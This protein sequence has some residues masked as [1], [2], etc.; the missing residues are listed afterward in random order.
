VSCATGICAAVDKT[1]HAIVYSGTSWGTL[2][3]IDP[4]QSL[5]SVS[6]T[7]SSFC[8]AV[9]NDGNALTYGG[10]SWTSA[11]IDGTKPLTG[12]SC[13]SSSFCAAVDDAGNAVV[14]GGTSWTVTS[15]DGTTALTAVSC[16]SSSFCAAADGGGAAMTYDGKNWSSPIQADS[17]EANITGLSCASS[18]LCVAVDA[19]N[20]SFLYAPTVTSINTSGLQS[21]VGLP[22]DITAQV[23]SNLASRTPSG[24]VKVSDGIQSCTATLAGSAGIATGTCSLTEQT[25]GT[26]DFV[27]TYGPNS[28]FG[29]SN[30]ASASLTVGN[31]N[32]TTVLASSAAKVTYGH[33]QLATVSVTVSPQYAGS[34]PTGPVVLEASATTLCSVTLLAGTAKC[35]LLATQLAVGTY[36]L[37]AT[38]GGS[39]DFYGSASLPTTLTV[40]KESAKTT[41]KLSAGR[42]TDGHERSETF[43]VTVTAQFQGTIP[44]GKVQIRRGSTTLCTITLSKGAGS[45]RP[46]PS[47]LRAG[48]YRP[49]AY[50]AGSTDF[51]SAY[52]SR[53]TLTVRT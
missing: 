21:I 34:I 31:A 44:T 8:V 50:Y 13:T 45:C 1:G 46:A 17:Y 11:A 22:V 9:D 37:V 16:T 5:A 14:Y 18:D 38:Y 33:E 35:T 28:E 47:K 6:C 4:S 30:S 42:L 32:S 25:A 20:Y 41:F 43:S 52:S 23:T 53:R 29:A 36:R 48:S 26:Y 10:T 49:F 51:S 40:A 12:V 24:S 19:R 27:A 39:A 15:V 7:S 2:T 3:S